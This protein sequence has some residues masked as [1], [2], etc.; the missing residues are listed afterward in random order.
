ME[1]VTCP[2]CEAKG[3]YFAFQNMGDLPHRSGMVPCSTCLGTGWIRAVA[4]EWIEF[5]QA[6]REKRLLAGKTIGDAASALK[7]SPAQYSKIERGL[8]DG[9]EALRRLKGST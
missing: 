4:L 3:E 8:V 5:G 2:E 9:E 7:T 1:T 6:L